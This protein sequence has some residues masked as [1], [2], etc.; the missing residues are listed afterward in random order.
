MIGL[1]T[2]VLIR[3]LVQDDLLQ[4]QLANQL[5]EKIISLEKKVWICQ[6]TVCEVAW[7]LKKCYHLSK[8]K[9]HHI[10]LE[11][12]LTPQIKIENEEALWLELKDFETINGVGLADCLIARLNDQNGCTITYTFD[13]MAVARLPTLYKEVGHKR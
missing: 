3:Y 10:F 1:D 6:I 12:L 9:I 8:D 5:I 2:N 7:V 4:S 13:K 11:L